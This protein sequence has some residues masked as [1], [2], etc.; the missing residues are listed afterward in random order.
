MPWTKNVE[1]PG[2]RSHGAAA[3]CEFERKLH[4][5]HQGDT[6][7]DLWHSFYD[8]STWSKNV[9]IPNQSSKSPAALA[10]FGGRLHMVHLGQT[11]NKIWHSTF[12]G[13]A[14]TPNVA[15]PN[16]ASKA[17]PALCAVGNRL[18]MVHLGDVASQIWHSTF[19]GNV[20]SENVA[21][22]G[23]RAKDGP[24]L[25]LFNGDLH[26]IHV[27]EVSNQIWHSTLQNGKWS[28]NVVVA[29][30]K[31][32]STPALAVQ[33]GVLH[34]VHVGEITND[35]WYSKLDSHGKW[36]T[37]VPIP[38]QESRTAPALSPFGGKLHL[39]H[40]GTVS[41]ALWHST[42]GHVLSTIRVGVKVLL[43]SAGKPLVDDPT[44]ALWLANMKT[45]FG[46]HGF[47]VMHVGTEQLDLPE[48]RV[49]DVATCSMGNLTS[50][51]RDLF[52]HRNG[53]E[54]KDIAVYIVEAT[55]KTSNG[56]AAH[57]IGVPACIVVR[58]P[59]DWTLAHECGH[60]LGLP[61]VNDSERLMTGNGTGRITKTPPDLSGSEAVTVARSGYSVE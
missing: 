38:E 12:D 1:I 21:I 30:Q 53:L 34:M 56:C 16:Q 7:N 9:R 35:L 59:S 3:L 60:V 8:G 24:A 10:V 26:M 39:V 47:T 23:Q 5:V 4:L 32:R 41:H 51:Q 40:G 20:W 28:K 37:N 43:D 49:V 58:D 15:I 36:T 14:W 31:S 6:S 11:S 61:H 18:H 19:D 55:H 13:K 22:D 2:Q 25:T 27:G 52:A 46:E 17:A 48:Q 33:G 45:I 42:G 50:D 54:K 57:P 44:I 29:D